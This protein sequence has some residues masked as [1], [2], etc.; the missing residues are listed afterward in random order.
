V[1]TLAHAVLFDYHDA[2][3]DL[4]GSTAIRER[5]VRDAL[6]Y[7]D[8]L[9]LESHGDRSLELGA[10]DDL[11]GVLLLETGDPRASSERHRT[12]IRRFE[13]APAAERES[14]PL[15]RAL[16]VSYHHL[17]DAVDQIDGSRAAL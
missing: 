2:I 8:T 16:S 12:A 5:L 1:R 6:R 3:K 9:A 15:R 7:L 11:L 14:A 4:P 17:G 10:A 13:S